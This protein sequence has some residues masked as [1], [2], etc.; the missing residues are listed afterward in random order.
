[1]DIGKGIRRNGYPARASVER[2]GDEENRAPISQW[3]A[4]PGVTGIFVG[5]TSPQT[6][7][8]MRIENAQNASKVF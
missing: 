6:L 2:K 4:L 3:L 7:T 1:M 8:H 5:K